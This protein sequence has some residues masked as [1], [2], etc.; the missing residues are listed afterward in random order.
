MDTEALATIALASLLV[1]MVLGHLLGQPAVLGYV[2]T[3]SMSPTMEAGDG[4]VAVPSFLAPGVSVGDVVVYE[5]ET[6]EGGGL[7]THRVVAEREGGY[8]TKGDG[9]PFTDQDSGEPPVTEDR[10]QAKALQVGQHVVVIPGIGGAIGAIQAAAGYAVTYVAGLAGVGSLQG[11]QVSGVALVAFG[12]L[13]FA[14]STVGERRRRTRKRT[15]EGEPIDGRRVALVL[16]LLVL[17]PANYAMLG[18]S[19]THDFPVEDESVEHKVAATN[20]G[21]VAMLVVLDPVTSGASVEPGS[22]T[23][24]SGKSDSVSVSIGAGDGGTERVAEHRYFVLLPPPVLEALH[25][26]HPT[27]ALTAV[28]SVLGFGVLGLV[29]G[30]FGF[31]KLRLR[32][33]SRDLPLKTRLKRT[34]RR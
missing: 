16:L 24:A 15:V 31:G 2:E 5:A 9:N 21:L 26:V 13:L 7:T 20:Q 17:L 30:L 19:G 33:T 3:D 8:V 1:L 12:V 11:S 4:F 27:L 6:I 28:N 29:G 14:S 18:P 22:T 34:I 32:E 23:L 10:V 25:G